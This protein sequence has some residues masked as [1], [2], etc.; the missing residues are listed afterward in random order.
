MS[1]LIGDTVVL[2]GGGPTMTVGQ[3]SEP[4]ITC[5]WFDKDLHLQRDV[6]LRTT[7]KA[8]TSWGPTVPGVYQEPSIGGGCS[9]VFSR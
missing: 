4:W 2:K 7:L 6:F 1:F 5:Q 3:V 9:P 8:A